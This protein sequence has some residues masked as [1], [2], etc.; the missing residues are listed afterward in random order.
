M[1]V[2]YSNLEGFEKMSGNVDDA[3]SILDT[4]KAERS[5]WLMKCPQVV[6]RAWKEYGDAGQPLAKI[7]VSVD[8]LKT[9]DYPADIKVVDPAAPATLN[10]KA[11]V[12]ETSS[13]KQRKSAQSNKS[14]FM[15]E[16]MANGSATAPKSY[17]LNMSADI[18]PMC[19]LLETSQGK[20]G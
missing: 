12:D 1:G 10:K 6:A 5:V 3:S 14:E 18:V 11:E 19:V 20:I 4:S 16:L 7:T 13:A 17:S 9:N 15:M 2:R 8:P